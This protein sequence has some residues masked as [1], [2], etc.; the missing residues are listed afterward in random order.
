[1]GIARINLATKQGIAG[2]IP[3]KNETTSEFLY[4]LLQYYGKILD[5]YKHEGTLAEIRPSIL[6]QL[7]FA[8]P[9]KDEQEMIAHILSM[10]DD[11]YEHERSEEVLKLK[12]GLMQLLMT[13]TI[14]VNN[15]KKEMKDAETGN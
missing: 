4:Y 15:L 3:K 12:M 11:K 5:K 8:F 13:G 6:K 1:M 14:R 2:I 7:K 9:P 10:I